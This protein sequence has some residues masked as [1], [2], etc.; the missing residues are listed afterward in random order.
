MTG[1][2]A[3]CPTLRLKQVLFWGWVS[4]SAGHMREIT[5]NIQ[6]YA[7]GFNVSFSVPVKIKLFVLHVYLCNH[8]LWLDVVVCIDSEAE[9]V[10]VWTQEKEGAELGVWDSVSIRQA[11]N[12]KLKKWICNSW[13]VADLITWQFFSLS[14]QTVRSTST[15][16]VARSYDRQGAHPLA[17]FKKANP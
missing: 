10:I 14:S 5:F 12:L 1:F 9:S 3:F 4:N 17:L 2:S 11:V 13:F 7:N 15:G 16:P 6:N 8:P